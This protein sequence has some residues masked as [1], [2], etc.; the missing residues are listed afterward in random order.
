MPVN[1]NREQANTGEV[2]F[3][4]DVSEYQQHERSG[5]WYLTS[6]IIGGLL[7]LYSLISG[8]YLFTLVVVLF[9]IILFL[10]DT[11]P[12]MDV[13][14][15]ITE[16]GIIVGE[17]YYPFKEITSYWIV[18]NPPEVKTIYFTTKNVLKHRLQVNL[19]DND[20]LPIRDFLNQF[21][22]EDVDK[23][24]EPLSDRLSRVFKLH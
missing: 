18:Y 5:R 24:E 7:L 6:G 19:L 23:E 13:F 10:Q 4:W 16:A 11:Q 9:G 1:L 2:V 3:S 21:L 22:L 17:L 15:A 12:P 14:F 20:P 8:N